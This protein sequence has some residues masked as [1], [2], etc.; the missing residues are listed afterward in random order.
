M[1]DP[2]LNAAAQS[3]VD[4]AVRRGWQCGLQFTAWREGECLVDVCAGR[5]SREPNAPQVTRDTLFPVFSTAKPLLATA[6]HRA[7]ERGLMDYDAPLRTWWPEFVGAGKERLTLRE[8]LAYRSGM[9]GSRPRAMHDN[10]ELC[11]WARTVA[12]EPSKRYSKSTSSF[13]RRTSLSLTSTRS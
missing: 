12:R 7:V 10:R 3:I 8:A 9:N 4:E 13:Q 2:V 6:V 11:D 1:P 5:L